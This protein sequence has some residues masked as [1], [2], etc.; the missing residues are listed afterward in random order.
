MRAWR[1]QSHSLASASRLNIEF[2]YILIVII[3]IY[4]GYLTWVYLAWNIRGDYSR[5]SKARWELNPGQRV[6]LTQLLQ[7]CSLRKW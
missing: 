7:S 4:I 6:S 2:L 3:P 5:Q 1:T